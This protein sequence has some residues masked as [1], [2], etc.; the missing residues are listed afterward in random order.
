MALA[1]KMDG[2]NHNDLLHHGRRRAAGRQHLGSRDGR[3]G[4]IN[5]DNL[6][7]IIDCNRLQ[8]DGWVKDVMNVEPLERPLSRFGW[9]VIE[10]TA[11]TCKQVVEALQKAKSVPT[12]KPVVIIANTV[13]G[14]GVSFM[15]N[16][17]GWH[18]KTPNRRRAG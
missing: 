13:K 17:A 6:V 11:T 2:K 1:G 14:K 16:Q 18:G 5:L 10:S 4:T 9:E 12:G 7:G 3:P 15:E 8:I